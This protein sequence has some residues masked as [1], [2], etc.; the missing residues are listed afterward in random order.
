MISLQDPYTTWLL[1]TLIKTPNGHCT[2][3]MH[4][5]LHCTTICVHYCPLHYTT[6]F[7]SCWTPCL[8]REPSH[9]VGNCIL[10]RPQ[11]T[12]V[13]FSKRLQKQFWY[14][15]CY[16]LVTLTALN[17][18]RGAVA[19]SYAMFFWCVLQEVKSKVISGH[20]LDNWL[21]INDIHVKVIT[22]LMASESKNY[23]WKK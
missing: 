3:S 20:H 23:L 10:Y 6:P 5:A 16:G 21:C 2:F 18:Q 19:Q 7:P 13:L 11:L 8:P 1:P 12:L 15:T 9:S 4:T 14:T 22:S 17:K